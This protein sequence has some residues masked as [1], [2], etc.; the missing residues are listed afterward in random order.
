MGVDCERSAAFI[1]VWEVPSDGNT[2]TLPLMDTGIY[3]CTV[4][5]GDASTTTITSHDAP[6]R[7]HAYA[8]AGS[9]T[10]TVRKRF[11]PS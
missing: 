1:S 9:Y 5:W 10:V 11:P 4:E 8:L 2:I 6:Q 7:T 3:N